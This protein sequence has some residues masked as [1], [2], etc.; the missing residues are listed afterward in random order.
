MFF[1]TQWREPAS[2]GGEY[3]DEARTAVLT[4]K[5]WMLACQGDYGCTD[6]ICGG[7]GNAGVAS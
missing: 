5:S 2:T 7:M 6:G 3:G 1:G 4:T